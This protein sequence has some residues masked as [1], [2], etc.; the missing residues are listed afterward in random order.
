M[1]GGDSRRNTAAKKVGRINPGD[2]QIQEAAWIIRQGGIVAYPT[3]SFYGLGVDPTM[4]DGVERLFRVKG[5]KKD[6]PILLLVA[7]TGVLS[8]LVKN[9]TPEAHRLMDGLWPGGLTLVLAASERIPPAITAGTGKVG[10]RIS[11]HPAAALLVQAAGGIITGTSANLS[12]RPPCRFA[13]EVFQQLGSRVDMI[14]DG[15]VTPGKNAS[16]VLDVSENPP[17]IL[18]EGMVS[19]KEIENYVDLA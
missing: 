10:I 5:R 6:Q 7:S 3:E 13:E 4:E 11:S 17:R 8:R 15:G 19:R 16:T 1:R 18:R 14:L 9:I 2:K 12:G